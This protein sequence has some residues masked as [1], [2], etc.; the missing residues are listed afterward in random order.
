MVHN[1]AERKVA[2]DPNDATVDTLFRM[3]NIVDENQTITINGTECDDLYSDLADNDVVTITDTPIETEE[4]ITIE[5]V[6]SI[7][8]R[9]QLINVSTMEELLVELNNSDEEWE[10]T[11]A[12][13]FSN[14]RIKAIIRNTDF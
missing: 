5:R 4:A 11:P 13:E 14:G 7:G 8:A 3:A 1:G 6:R 2:L 9:Y 10:L 12:V